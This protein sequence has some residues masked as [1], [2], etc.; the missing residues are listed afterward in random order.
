MTQLIAI[1]D[2]NEKESAPSKNEIWEDLEVGF[3]IENWKKLNKVQVPLC[4][5]SASHQV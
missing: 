2:K 1:E 5:A 4:E 3:K